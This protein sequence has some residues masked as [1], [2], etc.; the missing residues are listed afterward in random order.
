M[1]EQKNKNKQSLK[2]ILSNN[3]FIIK[4]SFQTAPF[5]MIY[6]IFEAVKQRCLVFL[7]HTYG[8]KFVLEAAEYQKPFIVVVRFL[9]IVFAAWAISFI[10]SGIYQNRV[11]QKGLPKIQKRLKEL[12]YERV[13]AL[14]LECYDDPTYYNEFVLSL[15][16][17]EKSITR[18]HQIIEAFFGGVTTLITSGIFFLTTDSPSVLFVLG[19]FG[20]TFFFAQI[21][22]KVNYKNRIEKNPEERKRT[23]IHRVFYLNEYAKEI[24]LNPDMSERLYEEFD[25]TNDNLYLIEKSYAKKRT[26]LQFLVNYV[27]ND[28]ISDVIYITYL[29]YR[30]AIMHAISYSSVV[31]LWN[32]S[33][34]LKN[35]LRNISRIFP[36]IS[37]NSLYIEKIR[38]FLNYETKIISTKNLPMPNV[39]KT[40]EFK[41]V[42]FGYN[43]EDGNILH[44]VNLIIHPNQKIALVGYNGAGK[45]TLIKLIM[46]LYDPSEGEIR[47]NG[48]NIKD[49]NV[50]EYRNMIGTIFQDFKIFA[51]SVSDNVIL[52]YMEDALKSKREKEI[53]HALTFSG[54]DYKLN[55][56][57]QGLSTELTTEFEE[58]GVDLSGGESQK[59]A[60]ARAFYKDARMV[61]LD[62]PSSALDP[63]AEYQL[64]ETMLQAAAN[65]T[66]I[67]ISHRLSTTRNADRILMLE[68]GQ[69]IEEGTHEELL[70]LKN[71]YAAMWK[72]QAGKY[73]DIE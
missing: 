18:T 8:I 11:S 50:K 48:I 33:G 53:R 40:L 62:E 23:Y 56:L 73:V 4:L 12:M 60:T 1:E 2:K 65:K 6:M 19:S 47:Y 41:N 69:I 49:Y 3:W 26:G 36:Q 66:V 10:F 17:A 52:D 63:I 64:N 72:A 46:R 32:S 14:D 29:V 61:I 58:D 38:N 43:K 24:R 71:K 70:E 59:L 42:S 15:S 34:S 68:H 39:P 44:N 27:T 57:P 13:K 55:S 16:E 45:T 20:L 7:E 54:F 37:E 22:N 30:A 31:V 25:T 28:F 9:L 35:S 5:F 21:L 67:F 51:A